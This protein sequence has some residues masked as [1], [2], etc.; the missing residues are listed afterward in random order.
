MADKDSASSSSN[1]RN[2]LAKF[3]STNERIAFGDWYFRAQAFFNAYNTL[4]VVETP[5]YKMPTFRDTKFELA[6]GQTYLGFGKPKTETEQ[7]TKRSNDAYNDIVQ[8]LQDKQVDLIRNIHIGNA[9]AVMAVLKSNYGQ[10]KSSASNLT[11]LSK[12]SENRKIASE[13]MNDY[14]ARTERI[15]HDIQS[16]DQSTM[17]NNT[18]K[19]YLIHGISDDPEWKTITTIVSANDTEQN[20]SVDKL[21]QYL[22]SQDDEKLALK[23][24]N[25]KDTNNNTNNNQALSTM[26]NKPSFRYRGRGKGRSTFHYNHRNNNSSSDSPRG[27]G[28]NNF[29]GR[30]R[31]NFR[32]NRGSGHRFN[33]S[34]IT[35]FTCG[36]PNH[37]SSECRDNP[38]ANI[39]CNMC[40]R[41]GHKAANCHSQKRRRD[42]D[43]Q[44]NSSFSSMSTS[45]S[46]AQSSKR[47]KPEVYVVI[48]TSSMTPSSSSQSVTAAFH[49][50]S[51]NIINW[52]LDSGATDHYVSDLSLLT[53][54]KNVDPPRTVITANGQSTCTYKGSTTIT[55]LNQSSFTLMNVLYVPNFH[56]NLVSVAKISDTGAYIVF[57]KTHAYIMRDDEIRVTFTRHGDVWI[58]PSMTSTSSSSSSLSVSSTSSSSSSSSSSPLSTHAGDDS[59]SPSSSSSSSSSSTDID[60]VVVL[61]DSQRPIITTANVDL[62]RVVTIIYDL[63]LRLAHVNYNRIIQMI[64]NESFINNNIINK[65]VIKNEVKLLKM[66]RDIQCIGCLQGKMTRS[67]KTGSIATHVKSIM[68]LWVY[69]TMIILI[70]TMSGCKYISVIVDVYTQRTIIGVHKRKSDIAAYLV[71]L[72]KMYQTQHRLTLKHLHSDNGT[73]VCTDVV[74]TFLD[75]QGTIHTTSTIY[76]PQHNAIAERKI[77]TILGLMRAIMAHA[78]AYPPLYGEAV[79]FIEVILDRSITVHHKSRTPHEACTGVKPTIEYLRVWGC[80]VYY[81]VETKKGKFDIRSRAGIFIGYD[82]YNAAYYRILDLE[83]HE[84]RRTTNAK[85]FEKAFNG[86]KSLR[87]TMKD[88]IK[89]NDEVSVDNT[90]YKIGNDMTIDDY[91]PESVILNKEVMASMFDDKTITINNTNPIINDHTSI[92]AGDM[93]VIDRPIINEDDERVIDRENED[94][95]IIVDRSSDEEEQDRQQPISI[96]TRRSR[97]VT[98]QPDRMDPTAYVSL[99]AMYPSHHTFILSRQF[100]MDPNDYALLV[101]DEP[102]TYRQA[103]DSQDHREWKSAIDDELKAHEKNRTWSI[104]RH[105]SDMNVIGCRWVFKVKRDA[106]GNVSKYKARLVAKGYNQQEGIDYHDTFAPVLNARSFRILLAYS[107]LYNTQLDQLDVKTAFL[108]APVQEDIYISVP[109]GMDI[110]AG[111]VMKLNRALYGIKQAPREWHKEIDTTLH[112]LGY[113]SCIKD[114]C[115]YWKRT[116]TNNIII[117]G[118]FVDDMPTAYHRLDQSEWKEDKEKLKLKYELSELGDVHHVLGMKITRSSS[119]PSS[120]SSMT[121]RLTISQQSYTTDKLQLFN[122]DQ[123]N[124]DTTPELPSSSSSSKKQTSTVGITLHSDQLHAYQMM[125][126]SLIYASISTRP[127]ITHAVNQVARHMSA[128]TD[129]HMKMVKRIFRYLNGTRTH[130]LEYSNSKQSSKIVLS[131]YCDADWGG[132]LTDRKSTTG[133]C[134]FMNGNLISWQTKKQTT[135]ALSTAEAEYMAISD[136]AKEIMWMRMILTELQL[137]IETPTIIYVDN[138]PAI[139][140][141]EN[142]SDH[143]RTKHIDIRHYYI[144]DLVND[145]SVKLQ[146]IS[147]DNQLADIF[148]KALGPSIFIKLRDRLMTSSRHHHQM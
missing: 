123:S 51:P 80:D 45:S 48:S 35:C 43:D 40:K 29:R 14:F 124:S 5:I 114:T 37:T 10:I 60:D 70:E 119:T 32:S 78:S 97:R 134:T 128:P 146:W 24:R 96:M 52:I 135:V 9:Y 31:G 83:T 102:I 111:Y 100:R 57:K 132:D 122:M 33:S 27:R 50:S 131:G 58:L 6:S 15:I 117:L 4:E 105:T 73:E 127:D 94:D 145:G 3:P 76:T 101:L 38:D 140:I 12:L 21:K 55:P 41:M 46:D 99:Q 79:K 63:H 66:L 108:N 26:S 144:R 77:R 1:S 130:G 53:D 85:F 143:D 136:L 19:F 142:D 64:K 69:D 90:L 65:R 107:V 17:S 113:T 141:S 88:K 126:G 109:E 72:I 25:E 75:G 115:L 121:S 68:D 42:D 30:G 86:M 62:P 49:S 103:V 98:A 74:K 138:Q 2:R 67:P 129:V 44:L 112:T 93:S 91:L 18:K 11:L 120:S 147:T 71:K 106:N 16:L 125:V 139:R 20:W 81:Y 8:S 89:R 56:V 22:I 47:N 54:V 110:P 84:I 133:Y 23:Q 28:R 13:T 148:T 82:D 87:E 61:D 104:V 34:Q 36:K 116:R 7:L 137:S 118:L 92:D 39:R 59:L 95:N